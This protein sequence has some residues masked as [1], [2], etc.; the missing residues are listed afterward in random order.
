[1]PETALVLTHAGHG[2]VIRSLAAG[3]PLVCIPMGRDQPDVAARVVWHGAGVKL[4]T[5]A[6][7]SALKRQIT[8]VLDD[9]SFR[10]AARR[11][12]RAISQE[13]EQDLAVQ[14]LEALA[15]RH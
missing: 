3:V 14:E 9:V 10:D 1:M 7:P 4:A 6:K 12:A 5:K 15:L 2:T 13:T 8:E 11:M